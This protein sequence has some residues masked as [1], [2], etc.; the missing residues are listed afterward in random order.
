[1]RCGGGTLLRLLEVQP[2]GKRG[3]SW[4]DFANGA[5]VNAEEVLTGGETC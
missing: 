3:M 1:V 5:R 4:R 2:A